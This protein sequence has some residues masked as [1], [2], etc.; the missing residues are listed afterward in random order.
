MKM[1]RY[2]NGKTGAASDKVAAILAS[3][4]GHSIVGDEKK[5]SEKARE[6]LEEKALSL[7]IGTPEFIATLS[8]PELVERVKAAK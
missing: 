2:P 1:I 3:R 8:D 7:G 5:I 4:P 6:K